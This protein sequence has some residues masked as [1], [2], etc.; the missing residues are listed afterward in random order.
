MENNKD[1]AYEFLNKFPPVT[2]EEKKIPIEERTYAYGEI[3]AIIAN[4]SSEIIPLL[5]DQNMIDRC[6]MVFDFMKISNKSPY[7]DINA[8]SIVFGDFNP[9]KP[10]FEIVIDLMIEFVDDLK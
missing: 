1:N 3:N 6:G 10:R 8:I 4:Y 7:K 9:K 2:D 5:P